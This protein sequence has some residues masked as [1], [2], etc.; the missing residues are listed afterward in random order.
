M[1]LKLVRAISLHEMVSIVDE[2]MLFYIG[3]R[4]RLFIS[5]QRRGPKVLSG[6]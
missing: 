5:L 3:G 4:Y 2:V 6:R 1:L